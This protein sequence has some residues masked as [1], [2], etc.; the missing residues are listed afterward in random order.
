M[1][2]IEPV[3]LLCLLLLIAEPSFAQAIGG[4][5]TFLSGFTSWVLNNAIPAIGVIIIVAIGIGVAISRLGGAIFAVCGMAG[6]WIAANAQNLYNAW[7]G[8][9]G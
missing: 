1:K 5:G 3:A 7:V 9:G 8:G 2:K 6:I 4:N